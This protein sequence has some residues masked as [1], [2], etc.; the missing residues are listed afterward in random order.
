MRVFAVESIRQGRKMFGQESKGDQCGFMAL[1][2]ILFEQINPVCSA[3]MIDAILM[4]GNNLYLS[5]LHS[6]LIPDSA[7][8]TISDLPTVVRWCSNTPYLLKISLLLR[9]SFSTRGFV[10]KHY[11]D[12]FFRC[13]PKLIRSHVYTI[14]IDIQETQS[15]KL[16]VIPV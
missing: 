10:Y 8:V 3:N 11:V 13:E 9:N 2:L 15:Q 12:K 7:S 4:N 16:I 5:A 6:Q 14:M 1:C